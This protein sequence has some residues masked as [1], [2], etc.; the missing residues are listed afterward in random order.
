VAFAPQLLETLLEEYVIRRVIEGIKDE[1]KL[2]RAVREREQVAIEAANKVVSRHYRRTSVTV[3]PDR[4][5]PRTS[6]GEDI[7]I[8]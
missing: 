1:T 7:A 2:S 3:H 6:I 4:G 5:A 8:R